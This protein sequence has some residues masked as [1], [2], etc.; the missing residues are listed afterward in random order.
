[1]AP[2]PEERV[3]VAQSFSRVGCDYAGPLYVKVCKGPNA[4]AY[5]LIFTC[6]V[7]RA[8]HLELTSDMTAVEFL[9]GLRRMMN[10]RGKCRIMYSDNAQTFK[11]SSKVL[12]RMFDLEY[13][14]AVRDKL[15]L[16]GI[17]WR[18][19]TPRAPWKGGFYERLVQRAKR[20]LKK[21]LKKVTLTF[22]EMQ[23]VLTYVE[24]QINSRPLCDVSADKQDPLPL[25]PGH[26]VTGRNLQLLPS[27]RKPENTLERNWVL[28]QRIQKMFWKRWYSEYLAG[29][30]MKRKWMEAKDNLQVD[31]VVLVAED[32]LRK[33]DWCRG[34]VVAVHPGRDDLVRSVTLKTKK[35]LMRRPIQK[36]RMLEARTDQSDSEESVDHDNAKGFSS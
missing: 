4:K 5:I 31:D 9:Q 30:Q 27:V 35:G 11:A 22:N 13:K 10:R 3:T 18:F 12:H 34:R 1:M 33:L 15:K 14:L 2:L 7:T 36:L 23:T 17:D 24:A 32:N 21:I 16:E 29:L 28:Q 6:M 20:A 19:I 25:T 8:V 26:L